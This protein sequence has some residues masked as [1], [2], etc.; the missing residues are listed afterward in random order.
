MC[1]AIVQLRVS[2]AAADKVEGTVDG[3]KMRVGWMCNATINKN[4]LAVPG[5]A[6][7][8]TF[9]FKECPEHEFGI[10]NARSIADLALSVGIARV[11]GKSVYFPIPTGE[12]DKVVGRNNFNARVRE[13]K[14]LQKFLAAEISRIMSDE[15]R[16][17]DA[18]TIKKLDTNPDEII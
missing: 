8:Y 6:A 10:D 13:D 3:S 15:I 12:E 18:E 11:E 14:E 1:G 9:V 5:K 7:G 16:D 4:K 2:K 17:Q